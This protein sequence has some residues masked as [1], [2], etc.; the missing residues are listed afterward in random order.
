MNHQ[1]QPPIGIVVT[2][3]KNM[4]EA[5]GGLRNFIRHFR[6]C[7]GPDSDCHWLHKCKSRPQH[8]ISIVYIILCNRVAYKLYFGGFQTGEATVYKHDGTARQISWPRMILGGP[9]E[10]APYKIPMRGFQGFR[11]VYEPIF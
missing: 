5:N 9:F 3:G 6:E 7:C 2:W 11:Y 8:D 10:K 1:T 4:I